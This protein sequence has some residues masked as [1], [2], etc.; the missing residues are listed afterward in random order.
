MAEPSKKY[1][2]DSVLLF[3]SRSTIPVELSNLV[4]DIDIYEHLDSPFLTAQVAMV[5][6]TRL[7]DRLDIQGAEFVEI[8]LKLAFY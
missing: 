4:S 2:L 8:N 6:E 5:D 1:V 7:M 3:S